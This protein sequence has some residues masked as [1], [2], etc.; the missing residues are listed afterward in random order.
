VT[1]KYP[2][3]YSASLG[4]RTQPRKLNPY[5]INL[6]AFCSYAVLAETTVS[7]P[8]A[9]L[10]SGVSKFHLVIASI[11]SQNHSLLTMAHLLQIDTSPRS[12]RSVSRL[13]AKEF[14][15]QWI[16]TN[17]GSIVTYRDI[18]KEEIPHV[19]GEWLEASKS[20]GNALMTSDLF[21]SNELVDELF[22]ADR[23]LISIPIHNFTIPSTLK[24][25]IDLIMRKNLTFSVDNN[26]SQ[27]LLRD[28]KLLIIATYRDKYPGESSDLVIKNFEFYLRHVF[29]FMGID[30]ISF[31]YARNQSDDFVNSQPGINNA[32]KGIRS[33]IYHW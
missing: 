14:V 31:I 10:Y 8:K 11:L 2:C 27:G 1:K 29:G 3:V 17:P 18:Q 19:T 6:S 13:L 15:D 12:T 30:Y 9:V 5:C 21:L 20:A 22:L 33:F 24:A 32:R 25:Y 16:E 23:Y 4:Y 28:K 7:S 26:S